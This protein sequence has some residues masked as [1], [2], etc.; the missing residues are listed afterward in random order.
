[1]IHKQDHDP[2]REAACAKLPPQIMEK[3]FFAN[4]RTQPFE[5]ATAKVICQRCIVRDIC[6]EET[7]IGQ[8]G[9]IGIRAG[10][11]M[12][13]I[14]ALHSEYLAGTPVLDLVDRVLDEETPGFR[15]TYNMTAFPQ[16]PESSGYWE[17][18]R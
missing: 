18:K 17:P 15:L 7:I 10:L 1:M 2:L 16:S 11:G 6:L 9:K 4:G 13:A 14:D 5:Y 3:Y 8:R 12:V